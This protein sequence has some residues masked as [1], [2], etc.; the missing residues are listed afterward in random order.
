MTATNRFLSI[1]ATFLLSVPL[2]SSAQEG[3]WSGHVD[4]QGMRLPLVFHFSDEGCTMDSPAQ[5][6]KGIKTAWKREDNGKVKV[7]VPNINA[8]YEGQMKGDTITGTLRQH[9]FS[10]PL[11]LTP[12]EYR[13]SRPQT[14][15]PPFPY[16]TEEVSFVNGEAVLKGTLTLPHDCSENTPVL[17]MITG[18]GQQNRDEE[19]FGH[20]P[21]AVIADALAR[22][23]IATLRYDDRGFGES[24]GDLTNATTEDFK[25]D[26]LA[27][28]RLLRGRFKNVGAIG[29][30]EGGT[31]TMML[32][33]GGEVDFIVSL[34]GMAVS[35]SET[36]IEQNKT[37]LAAA[38]FPAEAVNKYC[39]ALR[40]C[41]QAIIA[42]QQ[43]AE[44]TDSA[45]PQ[46]LKQNFNQSIRQLSQPYYRYFLALDGR[47]YLQ[48]T[49]C[50]VLAM[51]GKLDS[52]VDFERNLEAIEKSLAGRDHKVVAFDNLN[53]LFQHCKT[54]SIT[55]YWQIEETFAP[56]A[57]AEIIE[58]IKAL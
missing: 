47:K 38:G 8:E 7:S 1:L 18:S 58:W 52:Q 43:P 36:L 4:V 17:L 5:G 50:P 6:A 16:T 15:T 41:H 19:V 44:L 46:I 2:S 29:H 20:K 31:I 23:G 24:S 25:N 42:G 39:D 9:G 45:L 3:T 14:P 27:G 55:E 28:I 32:A 49:R 26:A 48:G 56:E 33:A 13:P 40:E 35:G 57:L 22:D 21:F 30:S 34:A 54:G 53:H 12:G 37:V 11:N 51:N 10:L